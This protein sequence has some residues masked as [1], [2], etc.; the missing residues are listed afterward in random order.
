MAFVNACL[1]C[2]SIDMALTVV[3]TD[4]PPSA[5]AHTLVAN[6]DI[7]RIKA[8]IFFVNISTPPSTF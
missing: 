2:L 6:S 7:V 8:T 5:T 1:A 4:Q 3:L